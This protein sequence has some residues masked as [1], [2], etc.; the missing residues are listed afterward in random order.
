MKIADPSSTVSDLET[1]PRVQTR[2]VEL[3]NAEVDANHRRTDHMFAWLMG[4]QWIVGIILAFTVSPYAWDGATSYIHAHVWAAVLLGGAITSLPILLVWR[5]PGSVLTRHAVAVAQMLTSALL[6]HVTGGRIETHFHVFG[7]LAFLAFYRDWRVL[8]TATIVVGLDHFLRGVF[9]P[10]SVFGVLVTS[11][12]RW[13]EHVVWVLFEDVFLILAIRQ[14]QLAM[15]GIAQRQARLEGVNSVIERQVAERTAELQKENAERR[16]AE[17]A[18]IAAHQDLIASSRVAGMAEIATNVLHNVGNVLNSV[19]VSAGLVS[20]SVRRSKVSSLSRLADLLREH[21]ADLPNF[22]ANDPRARQIP[23]FLTQ[24]SEHLQTSQDTTLRELATLHGNIEHIKDI[25]AMQQSYA[26]VSGFK[27]IVDIPALVEDS[28]SLNVGAFSRHRIRV[29]RDFQPVPALNVDKHKVL[30]ILINLVRNAKYACDESDR[31]PKEITLRV[32]NGGDTVK[33]SV[34]DNGVGIPV[35]NLTRIFQHG[36]T[37]KSGGHGFGLH[38]SALAAR[39]LGGILVAHSDG[40]TSG[41]T[42][43][44]ELPLHPDQPLQ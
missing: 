36:F 22:L 40:P 21:E 20:D 23:T 31:D 33:I 35:E 29:V 18:L 30:Q 2:T 27:E 9:W 12:W 1:D 8:L 28:L 10:E 44:L 15:F 24:L 42:F 19:N 41:A 14:N 7:S 25:V 17:K 43:T 26:K 11:H 32:A 37:T 16:R 38:S 6:I 13:L 39:E 4:V 34:I 3:F 5:K